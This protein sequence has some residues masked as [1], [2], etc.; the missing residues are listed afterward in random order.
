M[1]LKQLTFGSNWTHAIR[2]GARLYSGGPGDPALGGD[3][4]PAIDAE[5]GSIV[6]PT[7]D[8]ARR[9]ILVGGLAVEIRMAVRAEASDGTESRGRVRRER[10]EE[11][12]DVVV[13]AKLGRAVEVGEGLH[14]SWQALLWT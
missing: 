14:Y 1:G 4:G 2:T 8:G 9:T 10:N 11:K 7:L 3:E 6:T 13:K 5:A 12:L